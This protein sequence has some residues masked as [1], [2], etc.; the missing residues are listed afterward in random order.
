MSARRGEVALCNQAKQKKSKHRFLGFPLWFPV[1]THKN[2]T[3]LI[4]STYY[5]AAGVE[6][7]S[8]NF[9][10]NFLIFINFV[11][12]TVLAFNYIKRFVK[13]TDN[14]KS[15]IIIVITM[16]FGGY[17]IFIIFCQIT[18]EISRWIKVKHLI[19]NDMNQNLKKIFEDKPNLFAKDENNFAEHSELVNQVSDIITSWTGSQPKGLRA[20]IAENKLTYTSYSNFTVYFDK[21]LGV[22]SISYYGLIALT[23]IHFIYVITSVIILFKV[24]YNYECIPRRLRPKNN[25]ELYYLPVQ[26]AALLIMFTI[27]LINNAINFIVVLECYSII[28]YFIISTYSFNI[29]FFAESCKK[30]NVHLTIKYI[31]MSII[32]STLMGAGWAC[33]HRSWGGLDFYRAEMLLTVSPE[34]IEIFAGYYPACSALLILTAF[35]IKTGLAPFHFWAAL[36]YY[37]IDNKLFFFF[38]NFASP[39]FMLIIAEFFLKTRL[40]ALSEVQL[41]LEVF[42]VLNIVIGAV[43]AISQRTIKTIFFYS[44]LT[45]SGQIILAISTFSTYNFFINEIFFNYFIV[46]TLSNGLLNILIFDKLIFYDIWTIKQLQRFQ[47]KRIKILATILLLNVAGFPFFGTFWIKLQMVISFIITSNWIVVVSM[48]L[49]ALFSMAYLWPL[50]NIIWTASP[51]CVFESTKETFHFKNAYTDFIIIITTFFFFVQGLVISKIFTT[52]AKKRAYFMYFERMFERVEKTIFGVN[53]YINTKFAHRAMPTRVG[54]HIS[55][56]RKEGYFSSFETSYHNWLEKYL[57]KGTFYEKILNNLD[58]LLQKHC[59][60]IATNEYKT[61]VQSFYL[62]RVLNCETYGMESVVGTLEVRDFINYI[63]LIFNETR[64]SIYTLTALMLLI[65]FF[66]CLV[67]Y[68]SFYPIWVKYNGSF[69]KKKNYAITVLQ[70]KKKKE[71]NY[72]YFSFLNNGELS[73]LALL[74]YGIFFSPKLLTVLMNFLFMGNAAIML[75]IILDIIF[76]F[77]VKLFIYFNYKFFKKKIRHSYAICDT[78]TKDHPSVD[79]ILKFF[80]KKNPNSQPYTYALRHKTHYYYSYRMYLRK[81]SIFKKKYIKNHDGKE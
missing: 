23:V 59:P 52:R 69:F 46:Y 42:G 28:V 13:I 16:G 67:M 34:G 80:A 15:G 61:M 3:E 60:S 64:N 70:R 38:Q 8:N 55:I 72:N 9:Y 53:E 24:T 56:P 58:K 32:A 62:K 76:I 45:N 37:Q 5:P 77:C 4:P 65:F 73:I 68:T 17:A 63:G 22:F 31:T 44:S 12:F 33:F 48:L 6:I 51:R 36:I 54:R 71:N 29:A 81:R 74:G 66:L 57:I 1:V 7:I 49:A 11:L 27:P 25:N 26:Y 50:G 2:V 35:A 40:S 21:A 20:L 78:D 14:I 30:K 47:E 79:E 19:I 39:I 18:Q 43:A 75:V 10:V 41:M